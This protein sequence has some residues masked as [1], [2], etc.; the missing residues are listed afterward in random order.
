LGHK[1]HPIGLRLGIIRT[2]DSRWYAERDSYRR[3]LHEDVRIRKYVKGEHYQSGISRIEIERAAGKVK[4]TIHSA[5]PGFIIGKRGAGVEKLK[6][7]IQRYTK[8]EVF[9]NIQEVRKAELD[10]Q[11]I[12][13][14]VASQLERR[15]AFRRA[16]KKTITTATKFGAKG[17]KIRCGGRL[18]GAEMARKEWYREGRVPLQTLRADIEFGTAVAF[19]QYGTIGVK[20]WIFRGEVLPQAA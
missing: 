4:V 20:V 1:V 19:T 15:V 12:A 13:E 2:W 3:W 16:M 5:R 6:E 18:A 17:V 14:N 7:D 11:L 9:I 8:D 10:A